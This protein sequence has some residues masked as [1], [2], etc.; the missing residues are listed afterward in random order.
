MI[1]DFDDFDIWKSEV[2]IYKVRYLPPNKK[3]RSALESE[4]QSHL[5]HTKVSL[6]DHKV[7][8][9]RSSIN[10]CEPL[11]P[12]DIVCTW[13]RST[14]G[15]YSCTVPLRTSSQSCILCRNTW[16]RSRRHRCLCHCRRARVCRGCLTSGSFRKNPVM[17][18]S[19]LGLLPPAIYG[20]DY[21]AAVGTYICLF[22]ALCAAPH[23]S[24]ERAPPGQCSASWPE[25]RHQSGPSTRRP[26]SENWAASSSKS[27]LCTS[28]TYRDTCT[29]VASR[30]AH[31]V[32][33]ITR[34]VSCGL[35]Y[36]IVGRSIMMSKYL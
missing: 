18:L 10:T 16:G 17:V 36:S 25:M 28:P 9:V 27:W 26:Q 20:L 13:L 3:N 21:E 30:F 31:A 8:G 12:C 11:F 34:S 1:Y 2:I 23:R 24:V 6:I 14:S 29:P 22:V 33:K 7:I 4:S 32:N 19:I 35:I 5:S 15:K